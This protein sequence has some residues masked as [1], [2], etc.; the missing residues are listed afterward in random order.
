MNRR[1]LLAALAGTGLAG[2]AGCVSLDSAPDAGTGPGSNALADANVSVPETGAPPDVDAPTDDF[3]AGNAN[4]GF[5]L[6][7]RLADDSPDENR[8]L[9]PYSIGV[10][11]AMTAA[12]ARGTT[13]ETLVET[14]R[15]PAVGEDL[16]RACAA[17]RA[18]L[19]LADD[20]EE[21]ASTTDGDETTESGESEGAA[22]ESA[23]SEFTLAG[24]NAMWGQT[25]Y[26]FREDFQRTLTQYYGTGLGAVDFREDP[27]AGREA[28]NAWV[29]ERTREKVPELFPKNTIDQRTRL[30]LANAVY[31]RANWAEDFEADDTQRETFTALDGSTGEVPMMRQEESFPFA[32]VEGGNEADEANEA[33]GANAVG[34]TKVLEL[35]YDGGDVDM[36]L[37]MPPREQFREFEQSLDADRLDRLVDA[38]ERRGVEVGLPR[39]EFRSRLGL[40]DHLQ[41][42][43]MT[44]AFTREANFD[45]IAEGDADDELALGAVRHEAYV[46]VDEQGTE[47]AA[48]TGAEVVMTSATSADAEF[49]ADRPF[50]FVVRHGT[51]GAPLFVGR[52]VDATAAQ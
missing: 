17:L 5:A 45:G 51:T 3:V 42:M 36:V 29:A 43:G 2:V 11:L 22:G 35:P 32:E 39:F 1:R 27:E 10:A 46:R 47:A 28:I 14:M 16:H 8:F 31:F 49:V 19:P 6:L 26:P 9:S 50:L 25:G 52:M 24:A 34:G 38:T 23:E 4:F 7:D 20:G 13:R 37:L 18:D 33:D 48:A 15:F 21:S 12:G 40:A 30:V 41:A 44:T